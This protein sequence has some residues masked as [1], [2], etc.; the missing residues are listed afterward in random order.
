MLDFFHQEGFD[1][2]AFLQVV[3]A[4]DADT[5]LEK[6]VRTSFAS[7]LKRLSEEILPSWITTLSRTTRICA[8]CDVPS[9]TYAP[10]MVPHA[11]DLEGLADGR[12]QARPL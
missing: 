12:D 4:V 5:A 9:L 8:S 7:S 11:R 3:E 2:V 1:D 6:L 10:A